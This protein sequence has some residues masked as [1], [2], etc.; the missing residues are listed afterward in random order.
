M[1]LIRDFCVRKE[2]GEIRKRE[3]GLIKRDY[4]SYK[5][6]DTLENSNFDHS[7][8]RVKSF[9]SKSSK[10]IYFRTVAEYITKLLLLT[11][12]EIVEDEDVTR[13]GFDRFLVKSPL[14]SSNP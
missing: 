5:T 12:I 4:L 13:R 9:T 8:Y 10:S 2:C 3:W 14:T 7:N 11:E 1:Y 6:L